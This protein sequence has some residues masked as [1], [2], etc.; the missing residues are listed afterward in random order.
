MGVRVTFELNGPQE[1]TAALEGGTLAALWQLSRRRFPLLYA[2]GVRYQRE[3][4]G[5]EEWRLPAQVLRAGHG[6]CEDLVMWRAA[7]LR[8]QG[9]RARPW[10]YQVR[11]GLIHCV[12]K[13]ADGRVEDPSR[14]LG[15]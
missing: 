10:C 3:P 15:M 5:S 7:E 12:V 14:K 1:I 9:E 6:D 2:S 8:L 13:R 4:E 11:P